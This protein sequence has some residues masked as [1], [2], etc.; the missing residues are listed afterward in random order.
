MK[1]LFSDL[2]RA[3]ASTLALTVVC[4][5]LYPLAVW[6]VAQLAFPRQA[7]G[8]LILDGRGNTLGSEW[9]GQGFSAA[10]YFHS[11]PS[12]AGNGYDA[13]SSGGSNWGPTSRKLAEAIQDRLAAYRAENGLGAS[14]LVPADAV[15]ASASGL[16][17]Q[18]SARNA[19]LQAARVARARGVPLEQVL[20]IVRQNT[21]PPQWG[22]WGETRVNV[23]PLNL[24]LDK[25]PRNSARFSIAPAAR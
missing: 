25:L 17:P 5:G 4:G 9:I 10:R 16:D 23:L 2:R 8:S 12:A 14:E 19:E 1:S 21:Q 20:S 7:N 13:T 22:I 18:I 24:A 11:R 15:T 3:L 6:G